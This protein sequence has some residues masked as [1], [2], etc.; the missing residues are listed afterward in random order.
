[1]SFILR[2]C[3][4]GKFALDFMLKLWQ[5]FGP[6]TM[7]QRLML[8]QQ[9]LQH[10]LGRTHQKL[11][12]SQ[13]ATPKTATAI[14]TTRHLAKNATATNYVNYAFGC[15]MRLHKFPNCQPALLQAMQQQR[16]E[17]L[18]KWNGW[19][20]GGGEWRWRVGGLGCNIR[21]ALA[22]YLV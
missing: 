11:S 13:R 21:G 6:S 1:M 8:M 15:R 14:T 20:N 18:G 19:E 4:W 2:M 9:Q 22:T 3:L 17:K 12:D 7:H 16:R 5:I 10:R